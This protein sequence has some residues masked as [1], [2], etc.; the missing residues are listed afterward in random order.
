MFFAMLKIALTDQCHLKRGVLTK[1]FRRIQKI[2]K[3]S[4]KKVQKKNFPKHP[5][6]NDTGQ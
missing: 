3:K 6:L 2:L 1:Y 5:F 4:Q